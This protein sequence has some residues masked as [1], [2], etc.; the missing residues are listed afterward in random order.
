MPVSRV[1][2]TP[3]YTL[4]VTLRGSRPVVW[5]RLEVQG[6]MTLPQLHV[7]LQALMGWLDYHLH[8]FVAD[9][10]TYG[11]PELLDE[12]AHEDYTLVRLGEVAPHPGARLAYNY[13]FGDDW[14][15][16]LLVEAIG[17]PDPV[18][19][20]PRCTAGRLGTPPE[21][22]GGLDG[23]TAFRRAIRDPRHPEHA[24]LVAWAGG[25]F[26]PAAFD[27]ARAN[28]RLRGPWPRGHP[29]VGDR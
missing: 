23:Y 4:R 15:L 20:Y 7:T 2:R 16:D 11:D 3:I 17:P 28:A 24:E 18:A 8:A 21:D 29:P 25:R 14:W 12:L 6:T 22:V 13:D 1:T 26:D 5:R 19:R 10:V 27:V 9:G